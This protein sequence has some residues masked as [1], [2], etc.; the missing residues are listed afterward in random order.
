MF[1]FNGYSNGS[2]PVAGLTT[3]A[4]G[5][6]FGT[7]EGGLG[8][9]STVFEIQNT[10]TVAAPIYASAPT[11]LALIEGDP[12][13]GLTADANGNLFGTTTSGGGG[14]GTVFEMKNAG[15][16]AAPVYTSGPTTLVSFDRLS[17]G[18]EP[19]A[20]LTA[21][22]NGNLF[23]TTSQ[24]GVGGDGT[25]FEIQNIGTVTAPAYAS[26]PITLVSFNGPNGAYP[27]FGRLTVNANG[28]LFGTT[29]EGGANN[30]GMVF[31]IQNTG[32]VAAPVYAS[33]PTTLVSFNGYDGANPYA[34][35]IADA[36]GDLF[37]TTEAGGTYGYGT[38]FEI[39]N[40]G[41]VAAP[42]YASAPIT[43]VSFNSSNG[44]NPYAGLTA[45]A[46]G[47]LFGTT[48]AG[49]T[50]GYG[51]VFE[52]Q[53]TGAVA[54]P[55]YASAPI[56]LVSFNSSNGA[57]PLCRTDCRCHR[58]PVGHDLFW[59]GERRRHG[60]RD[61]GASDGFGNDRRPDDDVGGAGQ[62]VRPCDDWRRQRQRDRYADD[63][64]RRRGRDAERNGAERRNRRRLY[65]VRNSGRDHQRTR[66]PR[67]HAQG[68][69]AQHVLNDDVHAQRPEQRRRRAYR[70]QHDQRD[71][72]RPCGRTDHFGDGFRP[73]DDLGNAGQAVRPCDDWRRQCQRDR[74]ADDHP[75]R[76]GRDA[77]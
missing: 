17:N 26:V 73:D 46:N 4:N 27:S 76:R 51:T 16:V 41:A 34:G 49:G 75:R 71:R 65:T 9:P 43:L 74:N 39:Q 77:R 54:A 61:H 22:A 36:S 21:D 11:T 45:D 72:Q 50:Y 55:I 14:Y 30:K 64:P 1:S 35:L 37:G 69:R 62:A 42:V 40:T 23:G 15:T 59:W 67:L 33:A 20:G 13:G 44:A 63:H 5:N 28:D 24:E 60:V 8:S 2:E 48:E 57:T 66:R 32:T 10:G 19:F 3:D 38:V 70:R 31:E 25:V 12:K 18:E 6:L 56:T 68:G 47:D 52:I 58:Q 53:N 29:Q 7:T